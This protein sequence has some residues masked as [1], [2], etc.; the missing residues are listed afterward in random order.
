MVLDSIELLERLLKALP[1]V[2]EA[3]LNSYLDPLA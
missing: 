2:A 3:E 1:L